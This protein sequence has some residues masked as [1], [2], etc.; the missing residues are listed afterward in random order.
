MFDKLKK[1]LNQKRKTVIEVGYF[2]GNEINLLPSIAVWNEFGTYNI[3]P[4]PF[5]R[6][7]V[8]DYRK[9]WSKEFYKPSQER[10][11]TVRHDLRITIER[12][13]FTE[14][15]PI[16]IY[17]GWIKNKKSGKPFYVKGKGNKPPLTDTGT[18]SNEI[19]IRIS[20]TGGRNELASNS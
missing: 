7:T 3:P 13:D 1:I 14:N 4:R 15:A 9:K 2:D 12:G 5:I 19:K 11:E 18:L 16:T 20:T 17:S 10:A 8:S 6:N